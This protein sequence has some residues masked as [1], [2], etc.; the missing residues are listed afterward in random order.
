M[1]STTGAAASSRRRGTLCTSRFK[2][3]NRAERWERGGPTLRNLKRNTTA[4]TTREEE[5]EEGCSHCGAQR[6][7]VGDRQQGYDD[8]VM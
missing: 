8:E 7:P 1:F 2:T 6:K 3:I 5:E 4:F